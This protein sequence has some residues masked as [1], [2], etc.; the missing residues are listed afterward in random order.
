MRI[1]VT[2]GAGFIGSNFVRFIVDKYPGYKVVA[3]DNLSPY[4]NRRNISDLEKEGKIVFE[5]ADITD[6]KSVEAIYRK[7]DIG[8]VVNFAA[9]SHNDR[10][11][12]NPSIFAK[13]NALGAQQILEVSRQL[14]IKRHIHVS[15]IEVYGEQGKDVPYFTEKSPLNAKTPYSSAKA[16]GDL[17][18]RSYMHTYKDM[19]ICITH[20]ANNYGPYQFPEKLIPLAVSNLMQGK[21]IALYGDG[22]QKRD[23]LHVYDHCRAIDLILHMKEKVVFDEEAAT[24][25][26]KLPIYDISARKEVTNIE[27][28]RMILEEMNLEFDKWVEF[29]AD[30]PNHDRRYL[31]NPEKIET[32]LGFSPSIEFNDGIRETVRW[33]RDNKKWWEDILSRSENLQLDWSKK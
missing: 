3:L 24:D 1:L 20:C 6:V 18:V 19:D 31:I 13:T 4:S 14:K 12:L 28:A 10:A 30:R 9:E 25:S 27:I 16:A 2:G 8:Y 23:W 26:S 33:Y 21:K 15:T 11:I 5:K 7:H 17:L 32:Q 29:V 22:M